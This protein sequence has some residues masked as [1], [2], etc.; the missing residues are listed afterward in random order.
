MFTLL[1]I[2]GLATLCV[3]QGQVIVPKDLAAVPSSSRNQLRRQHSD[4]SQFDAIELAQPSKT[5]ETTRKLNDYFFSSLSK[6][7][8]ERSINASEADDFATTPRLRHRNL[9]TDSNT[10]KSKF[11]QSLIDVRI[12]YE[13][14]YQKLPSELGLFLLITAFVVSLALICCCCAYPF[15]YCYEL[16]LF[17]QMK[18]LAAADDTDDDD[19]SDDDVHQDLGDRKADND[20]VDKDEDTVRGD[21]DPSVFQGEC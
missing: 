4:Q 10:K 11:S 18:R 17:N 6:E 19:S 2:V 9:Q 7:S 8:K 1:S 13:Y 20:T 21:D 16:H 14:A 5:S 3:T 15:F 12:H